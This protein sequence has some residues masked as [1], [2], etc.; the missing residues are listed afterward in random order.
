MEIFLIRHGKTMGNLYHRYIGTT[1]EPV[2]EEEME[3][4]KSRNWPDA[5]AVF[6][7][8]LLRCRQT[9]EII[10][11]GRPVRMID[12]FAECDFGSFENKNW[13]E[14]KDN[15]E[16]QAWIDSNGTLP[17]P[18]GE[19][20]YEFRKRCCY[21]FEKVVAECMHRKISRALLV[22]HGGTI[23]SI[24]E[25]YVVSEKSF[26]DWH[27]KNGEGYLVIVEPSLWTSDRREIVTVHS[28]TSNTLCD[29]QKYEIGF[30]ECTGAV[31]E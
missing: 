30:G 27:V 29:A 7:S 21:G 2:L 18:G 11:P 8:P 1:D 22:V 9:A 20:P 17:F 3:K 28:V 10:C 6:E 24:M 25:R 15:T 12:E 13:Q 4:L 23:M 14:L 26:Y 5:E 19:D 31:G 16:Y